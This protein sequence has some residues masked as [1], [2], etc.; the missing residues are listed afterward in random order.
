MRVKRISAYAGVDPTAP[1]LH[2]GHLVTFMPL[3]WMYM[4]GY[5]AFTLIGS[6]TAKIGDPTGR[7]ESRPVLSSHQFV[8]NLTSIHYQLK[9]LWGHVSIIKNRFKYE[10]DWAARK[11]IINNNAWWNSQSML[12]V[13]SLL[14]SSLRMGPLLGRDNVKT[15]LESGAGMSFSEFAYPLMQ[16]WDWYQLFLQRGTQLQIGGSDQYGN[17]LTGAQCVKTANDNQPAPDKKHPMGTY[18]QPIGFTV[19]L[20]TDASGAKF[21]K[22]AGNAIWLDRFMTTPYDL[23]GYLIRRP[24]EQVEA[25]LKLLTFFPLKDIAK[26]MEAHAEDPSKRVAQHLLAWEVLSLV[27]G[28]ECA[29]ETQNEHRARHSSS[30]TI[31]PTPA[32]K[33]SE[34]PSQGP[35]NVSNMPRIDM[36]LPRSV[37]GLSLARIM[38]AAKMSTSISDGDRAIKAGG[39]YLGGSA[40]PSAMKPRAMNPLTLTFQP[41]RA[42]DPELNA[43]FLIDDRVLLIRKGKH[44][45]RVIEFLP[46]EEWEKL[47][48]KYP[49][50]PNQGAFRSAIVKI[51]QLAQKKQKQLADG[52]IA[53]EDAKVNMDEMNLPGSLKVSNRFSKAVGKLRKEGQVKDNDKW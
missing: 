10:K 11:G 4:H 52:A 29:N 42:W 1:S 21:G 53:P 17:I 35:I 46:D 14:G 13:L 5:G 25:L 49:G 36:K 33:D 19:P 8:Q 26:V 9:K 31:T 48:L 16:G 2:L 37:L 47:G 51:N 40:S 32:V 28:N 6:S 27:H 38:Y 23:Y 24:D 20:L 7:T 50:Q 41:V 30:M 12:E 22:S 39:V 3:F 18:D 15:K 45:V 34:D 43:K 44:N